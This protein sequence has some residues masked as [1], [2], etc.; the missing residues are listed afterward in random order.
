MVKRLLKQGMFGMDIGKFF[1]LL[2]QRKQLVLNISKKLLVVKLHYSKY[3]HFVKCIRHILSVIH[4]IA[5]T[6]VLL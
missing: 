5:K 3:V 6:N 4:I 1:V 2:T